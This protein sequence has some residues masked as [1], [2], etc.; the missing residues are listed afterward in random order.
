MKAK[1]RGTT[2]G[3]EEYHADTKARNTANMLQVIERLRVDRPNSK[4]SYKD[5]WVVAGLKSQIALDS[6]WNA[7]IKTEIDHHN[8]KIQS[9]VLSQGEN[10]EDGDDRLLIRELKA[11][12]KAIKGQRDRALARIAQ[13]CADTDHYKKR[14]KDLEKAVSRL[15][16]IVLSSR[17]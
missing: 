5:V 1:P 10:E 15:K 2:S 14:C 4:W 16:A 11:E 12:V 7:H 3:L 13:Y 9:S 6:P 17:R 8:K